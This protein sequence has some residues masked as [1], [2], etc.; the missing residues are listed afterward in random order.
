MN[1]VGLQSTHML[2]KLFRPQ[3]RAGAVTFLDGYSITRKFDGVAGT[4]PKI[5]AWQLGHVAALRRGLHGSVLCRPARV[6]TVLRKRGRDQATG[7]CRFRLFGHRNG[8]RH[9]AGNNDRRR[10]RRFAYR[11]KKLL[12]LGTLGRR[13]TSAT[14]AAEQQNTSKTLWC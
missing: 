3:P 7:P 8:R 13:A 9:F 11:P 12:G 1:R 10:C 6:G 4:T 2:P 5:P 14:G